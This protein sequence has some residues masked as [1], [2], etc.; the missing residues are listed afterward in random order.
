M[1]FTSIEDLMVE[2]DVNV[3]RLADIFRFILKYQIIAQAGGMEFAGLREYVPGMDDATKIDWKASLRA[4]KLYVKEYEDERD[5]DIHILLDSSSSMI[6]GTGEKLKSE[7]AAVLAST[8]A[9]AGIESGDNVGFTMFND[10][11]VEVIP[12]SND[13]VTYYRV[14]K[15]I[16]NPKYYGGGCNLEGAL[17]TLVN[18]VQEKTL[19]FIISDF[20]GVGEEWDKA[21]KMLSGK[22]TKVF[23]IMVRDERDSFIPPG[24]GYMRLSDPFSEKMMTLNLDA[25]RDEFNRA[26]AEQEEDYAEKFHESR[27]IMIKIFSNQQFVDPLVK[28][29]EL[30]D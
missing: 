5:L 2:V 12:P 23:G 26:A 25:V 29:L 1:E 8:L 17:S 14:L 18:T 9:Y 11:I 27:S 10:D 20:I 24:I 21:L 16:T 22:L 15:S 3:K 4:K 7:Y 28:Y 19:L 30:G 13:S 6:F